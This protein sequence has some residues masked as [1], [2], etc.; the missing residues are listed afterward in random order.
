MRSAVILRLTVQNINSREIGDVEINAS[1]DDSVGALLSVLPG[2]QEGDACFVGATMLDRRLRI[3]GGPLLPGAVLSVGGAGPD[4]QPVRRAAAGTLHV[5]AGP[6]AGF[7]V[8][9]R[10]GRYFVG[11][12]AESHV[13]LYDVDVSRVHALVEVSAEGTALLSDAGSRN[14]TWVNGAEV[15]GPTALDDGS[16]VGI[17]KDTLRWT[18]GVGRGLRVVQTADGRLEF[19]RVFAATPAIPL[20]EVDGPPAAPTHRNFAAMAT[21]GLV[22]LAMGPAMFAATHNPLT[23]F[24]SLAGP[25]APFVTYAVEG[26]G[27]RK[28][29]RAA[30]LARA[31]AREHLAALVAD[32]E[33]VRRQLAPGPAEVTAMAAGA[34]PD[35]WPRDARSPNGLVLRVGVTDQA[36]SVRLHGSPWDDL[37]VPVLHGVPVTVDLRETGVL[38]V[39]GTGE[40]ARALLRWLIVQ[41]ATL[42][43]PDDL[44]LVLLTCGDAQDNGDVRAGDTDLRWARCLPHLDGGGTAETPCLIGNTVASRAA[45]VR[46]LRQLITA[47]VAERGGSAPAP[48]G[49]GYGD[50]VVVIDGALALANLPGIRDVLLLG[51]EAGVYVVC[52]DSQGMSE[53]RGV[54]EL[55]ALPE[56]EAMNHDGPKA[57]QHLGVDPVMRAFADRLRLIRTPDSESVTGVPDGMDQAR[58]EQVARALAPMRDRI[59]AVPETAIPY[60]VR[61]LDLLGTGVPSAADILALWSGKRE[62]PSTRVVLG[63]DASGPVTVDLATEGPHTMLGGATEAGKSTLLQTL[64]TALL[65]ANRPDELNLVLADFK[66][67]GTFQPFENCPHVT[68]LIRFTGETAADTF[69]EADAARVLA[70]VRTEMSRREAILSPHGAEID[71]YWRARELQPA[72]P[73]L[74]RV[75]MIFDEFARVLE[76]SPD[77]LKELVNVAAK[78]RSLGVHLVL[79][80]QW[81]QGTLSPELKNNI[82]LRISLRQNEP[83]DSI[84]VLGA[85]DAVSIPVALRG[86]GMILCTKDESRTPRPFQS[87]YLGDPPPATSDAHLAVRT[88]TW[89]ELGVARPAPVTRSGAGATDQ[90]LVIKA[91]E[92]AARHIR[93]TARWPVA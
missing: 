52:A 40:P 82:D 29:K 33:H 58:A 17:G 2:V 92:E 3:A 70:S 83:A 85:P 90:T 23:L 16:V 56:F 77:F 36:P 67:G 74:P 45:R 8:A 11:R 80:T 87:G 5:I 75:V 18:A 88:V 76:V 13:C 64:V 66:G 4:Y 14:G 26:R 81:L 91:I 46:E 30:A 60:P 38:G 6:D 68:A 19:D 65:L 71:N 93:M 44:R 59:P 31:A 57:T 25:T 89:A 12:A 48:S 49:A 84:E 54:C 50:V 21:S 39:I 20:R 73:R 1:P 15:T 78:G 62:G 24:A 27:R 43:S 61:L 55:A 37:E 86:R 69:G 41:L 7:G 47:R 35:L 53:C 72:L 28:E 22:G 51:P 32:E 9:L 10:P 79:A 34:R 63:A 42:R